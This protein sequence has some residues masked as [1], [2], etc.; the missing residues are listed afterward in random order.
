M[1][2]R[3]VIP[4][5]ELL[6]YVADNMREADA[7]ECQLLSGQ[8]PLQAL[9]R[10]SKMSHHCSVVVVNGRPCA[11]VGLVVTSVLTGTGVP[12]LLATDYAV[13]QR[14]IFINNCKQG[15]DD[16]M[17]VCPNLKNF[18]HA[19]NTTSIRWLKWMGFTVEPSQPIG[20][21]G[22]HFHR[23]YIGDCHV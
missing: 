4:N 20:K 22:A 16:M 8:T 7:L 23:F 2:V 17:Q 11:V 19:D 5:D 12:W 13:K 10:G 18:V 14:R 15:L 9:Q 3:Y 21:D 1:S 6:R